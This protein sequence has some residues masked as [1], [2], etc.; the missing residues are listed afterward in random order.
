MIQ[1][2]HSRDVAPHAYNDAKTVRHVE[3]RLLVGPKQGA[4]NFAMR[5]FT[6]GVGGHTPRH[7]HPWE[8]EVYILA[9]RGEAR[10]AD[11]GTPVG[12]G[13]FVFVP[14]NDEHQFAN[15]SDAPFEF[16]CMVPL[17]GDDG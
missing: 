4:P 14:P 6:I 2:G 17:E 13:D 1:I 12:P 3:K 15:V 16:L 8:H 10:S 5:R 11:G 7:N 9:G